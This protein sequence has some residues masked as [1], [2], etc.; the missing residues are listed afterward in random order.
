MQNTQKQPLLLGAYQFHQG[1][2]A[3]L[4]QKEIAINHSADGYQWVHL[5][6]DA[7]D[8]KQH[9]TQF[10]LEE[11]VIDA[12]SAEQTRPRTTNLSNGVLTI[13]RGINNNQNAEPEDMISLRIWFNRQFIVTT[14]M[15]GRKLA[16]VERLKSLFEVNKGPESVG[17]FMAV[18]MEFM[19][20]DISTVI[21]AIEAQVAEMESETVSISQLDRRSEVV[22]IRR[23]TAAIR[24]YLAP[25]REAIDG[26]NRVQLGFSEKELFDIKQQSDRTFR[27]I[28]DLDLVRE[29]AIF[30]HEEFR[31]FVSEQQN[32]R[33]YFLSIITAIFLP[34]S[35]ITGLFGMNVGGMPLI[36]H[37]GGF[38]Y[39][40]LGMGTLAIIVLLI[41]YIRRWL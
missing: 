28:E 1:K 11:N 41:I 21:D 9:L 25:Q 40:T 26:L 38:L 15:Q 3:S 6:Y 32:A 14:R 39:L 31:N 5:H 19:V 29:R 4:M 17:A 35:F 8:T 36:N 24:R 7:E 10:G 37:E 20:D 34:L 33:M 18:L 13:L 12:L 23:Q 2:S 22:Q 27:H 16:F 30:L